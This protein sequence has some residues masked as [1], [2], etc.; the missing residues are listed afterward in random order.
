MLFDLTFPCYLTIFSG[1]WRLSGKVICAFFFLPLIEVLLYLTNHLCKT[2]VMTFAD[3]PDLRSCI[4]TIWRTK[5][6]VSGGAL[7]YRSLCKRTWKLP[8]S[9]STE[10][11]N[12]SHLPLWQLGSMPRQ[13]NREDMESR[14][15][16]YFPL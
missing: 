7:C 3:I 12:V 1:K 9:C 10:D 11:R 2:E 4:G 14:E 6:T 15:S 16:Q 5:I 13:H 8:R